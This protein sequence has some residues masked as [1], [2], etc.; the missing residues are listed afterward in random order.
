[1][2]N[3]ASA[4]VIEQALALGLQLADIADG[5]TMARFRAADLVVETKPDLTPVSEA[6]QAVERAVRAHLHEAASHHAVLGEE[7][8]ADEGGEDAEFRWIVDPIDG[9]KNYVRGVPVWATLLG[10]EYRGQLVVGVVSAPAMGER[11]WAGS[12][13]GAFR[14]GTRISCSNVATL[15]DAQ[16]SCAW[17][18]VGAFDTKLMDLAHRC[19]RTRGF[20]DYWQHV[21]VADGS[22]DISIDPILNYWDLAALVPILDE[23]G[24]VWSTTDGRT[25][26]RT[27][28]SLVCSAPKLHESVLAALR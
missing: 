5:I 10:L 28:D 4:D 26:P 23:S 11:W 7:Y 18:T 6:D 20:G 17:D 27:A 2:D 19:W 15:D 21:M 12:G 22:C 16:L 9:T 13:L 1:M 8:G 24:A 25:D 3:D 14:D